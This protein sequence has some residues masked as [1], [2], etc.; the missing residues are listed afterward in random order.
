[1][2]SRGLSHITSLALPEDFE[3]IRDETLVF[4]SLFFS[5]LPVFGLLSPK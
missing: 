4:L 2:R 1:M 5:S 3:R